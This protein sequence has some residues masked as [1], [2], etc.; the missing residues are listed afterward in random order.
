M[1][2]LFEKLARLVSQGE[3]AVL[4]TVIERRGFGAR[5][6][7]GQD[8][9]HRGRSHAG[10]RGCGALEFRAIARARPMPGQETLE[11]AR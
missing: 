11:L 6:A 2:T 7:G 3:E 1:E 5:R 4:V 8:A 10:Y 9:G